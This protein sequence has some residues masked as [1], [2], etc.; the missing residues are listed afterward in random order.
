MSGPEKKMSKVL[1]YQ[2]AVWIREHVEDA[3]SQLSDARSEL[4]SFFH[5][6]PL[7]HLEKVYEIL[8]ADGFLNCK[9]MNGKEIPIP[10]LLQLRQTLGGVNPPLG[11]SGKC[12]ESHLLNLRNS[13][14]CRQ[15][16]VLVPPDQHRNLS[17]TSASTEFG[18]SAVCNTSNASF[19][20]WFRDPLIQRL[21]AFA[22]SEFAVAESDGARSLIEAGMRAGEQMGSQ[23]GGR[24]SAWNVLARLLEAKA[25]KVT[26][27]N[28]ASCV[29]LACGFPPS[30]KGLIDFAGAT[31]VLE[32]LADALSDGFKTGMERI[33][34]NTNDAEDLLALDGCLA[35]LQT[36]CIVLTA[37]E[38]ATP[39]FYAP[40]G[41]DE[42][43][44][45]PSWWKH[46]TIEKWIELL[47]EEVV[48][49]S[50]LTIRVANSLVPAVKGGCA[51]V[52]DEVELAIANEGDGIGSVV[53]GVKRVTPARGSQQASW[54]LS[55]PGKTTAIDDQV[56]PHVAPLRYAADAIGFKPALLKVLSLASWAPGIYISSRT[57]TKLTPTRAAKA[58]REKVAYE[59]TLHLAGAGR[60]YVDLWIARPV[61]LISSVV[62]RDAGGEDLGA[63]NISAQVEK[64]DD[65]KWGFE[66][67][68]PG[69]C[70]LDF[71]V[72]RGGALVPELLRLHITCGEVVVTDCRSEFERVIGLNRLDERARGKQEV[73][74][75][76]H[77]RCSDLQSWMLEPANVGRSFMPIVLAEDYADSWVAPNWS[78]DIGPIL[79][80]GSF[81]HDPR[82]RPSDFE[83]SP[84][85]LEVRTA[86]AARIRGEDGTG[87]VE[88]AALGDWIGRDE[89][90]S[91]LIE[92]YLDEYLAWL[93]AA[94][95]TA[96]WSDVTLV[97]SLNPES[98]TLDQEP[99]AIILSPLHPIRLA[100]HCVAHKVLLDAVKL[101]S[102]CPAAS[103]LDPDCVPDVLA[104]PLRLANG[105]ILYAPF[106]SVEVDTDYWGVLW[107]GRRLSS[108][109]KR[110]QDG[111]FGV[112][113]GIQVGG[114]SSGFSSA[115]VM[116]A[117]DDATEMFSA[118]PRLNVLIASSSSSTDACTSGI[119]DW[120]GKQWGKSEGGNC[121]GQSLGPR[122][123][124][125][126]DTRKGTNTGPDE[127][128]ISNLTEDT[129]GAV[130]WFHGRPNS[131]VPDIGII[132]QLE[133]AAP[134]TESG[135]ENRSPLSAGAMIRH[136]IR[137]QLP[138]GQRAFLSESKQGHLQYPRSDS[139][140]NKVA[141]AVARLENLTEQVVGYSFAP[142]VHAIKHVL[143]DEKAVL[144]AVSSS[145]ID[146]ACFLGQWLGGACLWD[147]DLPSYSRRA[148]DTNGYYLISQIRESE[149]EG[150]KKVLSKLP[151]CSGIADDHLS[152][153]LLEISRRGIPTIRGISG[154]DSGGTGD[155]GLF[156][157]ARLL[158]DQFR[159]T[160]GADSLMKVMETVDNGAEL[161]LVVPVDPFRG[162][163]DDLS[164]ALRTD[165]KDG[166]L[167]RP[168]LL[169]VCVRLI[170]DAVSI[171]LTPV[172]V[173]CRQTGIFSTQAS[174]EAL[175]Q[176]AALSSL[177]SKL[178]EKAESPDLLIWKL[179]YQHLLISMIS[180]GLRVYSQQLAASNNSRTWSQYH[181]RIALEI[182]GDKPAVEIDLTGRLIVID[183]SSAGEVKDIDADG[184]AETIVLGTA[185]SGE[186]VV[187]DPRG[188][189]EAIKKRVGE[190][191]L[192]PTALGRSAANNLL[193]T[194]SPDGAAV[195]PLLA[196]ST[197]P[198]ENLD[199]EPNE[200]AAVE[201]HLN[202]S[203][204]AGEE[205]PPP[206]N[207][208]VAAKGIELR[209]G[210]SFDAFR[211]KERVLNISDT[212]LNQLN[213][214][215]VGDLG[216]GKTQ[217]LKS[218]IY[219]IANSARQNAGVAPRFLIFDY[220]KDYASDDFVNSVRAKV[221]KPYRL[222]I[223]LFDTSDL[224]DSATP[225]LDRFSFFADVLD[226]IYAGIG[227]VQ[228]SNLKQAV[229][230][231]YEVAALN[232]KQPT[233]YDVHSEYRTIL[234]GKLD[235]PFAI[236]DDLVDREVFSRDPAEGAGF[237]S[238]FD[239]V[240]VIS[241]GSLGQDD[242]AKNMLVAT[243]LNMFYEYMLKVPKRAY[244]GSDPQLRVIDSYLLVDEADNIMQYEFD[245]LKKVLLQGR[246]FGVGVILAS[247]YLK[248]FKVNAS[249]YREPL[250][251]W[252]IHKV[253]NV[254][255]QELA[256]LGLTADLAELAARVK[257]LPNHHCLYKSAN[258][259]GEV[260]LGMPFY[261]I[262]Q[263][264]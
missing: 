227:P 64:V 28:R 74:V 156:V 182:F 4:R 230:K 168:D 8:S 29:S 165:K 1:A 250:L 225:W 136:R 205:V 211:D 179:A 66:V 220:K 258:V 244:R 199:V 122:M 35:Q 218:L 131:A 127:A 12:D 107:N 262:I 160:G 51:L 181:E 36:S 38:R 133:S 252:F 49:K 222:P 236:I 212:R 202:K 167:S 216:T 253:P 193:N 23:G 91:Q 79:S 130:R 155:L 112:D 217:L 15:Y 14:T 257:Q 200:E 98:N 229:R 95:E 31:H 59:A 145:T 146:P 26:E 73:H 206:T 42:L 37:F 5:G 208:E 239:G 260:I 43:A 255:P 97:A 67:D 9:A 263:E 172:E 108:F 105:G 20:D 11:Q 190:W 144:V 149:K 226:K 71:G 58:N 249:D 180:F 235:S 54:V 40:F 214:G 210:S 80:A 231:A 10:I 62:G 115:Q 221:V 82:P 99:E 151:G 183:K 86:I 184:F 6:P 117:L 254:T 201:L 251:T 55:I 186:I 223:N 161:T 96:V 197:D 177:F 157:A 47:E 140:V 19:E 52:A 259:G 24:A 219:Q 103:I 113:F 189:Y 135:A 240:V 248:H 92:T 188:L 148:G 164:R 241:L 158:Q 126:F 88:A 75:N 194:L 256:G 76:R 110:S 84:K 114:V 83:P 33:R 109:A 132:A 22:T 137:R 154:H 234:N 170:G 69:D 147:Y 237:K 129:N 53:V 104:L 56:P 238:F 150:L 203:K 77:A 185:D 264:S 245:V 85:Y 90:F 125:V 68:I 65:L 246:E 61:S 176:A 34:Q 81:L 32:H 30:E 93:N 3:F 243:M 60:H 18:V 192:M 204:T 50:G 159:E 121:V 100:W 124:D 178:K 152:Q 123:L 138:G 143:N 261:R 48:D 72:L 247:Q 175:R 45:P 25:S 101:F 213:I 171:R 128:A 102:P 87:L 209:V 232:G 195:S 134:T 16:L 207:D 119:F 89:G 116:R 141:T 63:N 169:V 106:I 39:A 111:P 46:L 153:I 174:V 70:F 242:R 57:A 198:A 215:V 142:N 120:A 166:S 228:R 163:L 7:E 173:K 139:L 44:S 2:L 224:E 94:P 17:I 196:Q 13:P 233:I 187:G 162:Y 191:R 78:S 41:G 118:K 21:I 27:L